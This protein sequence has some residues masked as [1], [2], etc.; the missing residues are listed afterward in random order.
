MSTTLIGY[1]RVS[2]N[3]QNLDLQLD[4]L[5]AAGCVKTYSDKVSGATTSRP[6]LDECLS[7]LR[8]G[9]TLVV[10]RLDRLGRSLKHLVTLLGELRKQGVEF[11][12]IHE[13]IDTNTS[14]GQ[15]MF[16]IFGAFA[17]FERNLMAE[18]TNAGLK[19]ARERGKLGGR[20][21]A[22]TPEIAPRIVELRN[23]GRN[24]NSIAKELGIGRAT[25]Y[26]YLKTLE[27]AAA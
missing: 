11:K 10:W 12:S 23:E 15:L 18:R 22:V 21:P 19:A 7:Y 2:T 9:D 14:T 17:E 26:R 20:P 13:G 24:A 8:E 25:V 27:A 16:G 1:A 6:K 5:K 3:E 4:A